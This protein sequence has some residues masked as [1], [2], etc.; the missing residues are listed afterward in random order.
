MNSTPWRKN[1]TQLE[2]QLRDAG[3]EYKSLNEQHYA[4]TQE[5]SALHTKIFHLEAELSSAKN[6][7]MVTNSSIDE[8][9]LIKSLKDETSRLRETNMKA[10]ETVRQHHTN[11]MTAKHEA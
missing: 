5:L 3:A 9:G 8:P 7:I 11:Y 10:N 1:V 4:S 6:Q 2:G